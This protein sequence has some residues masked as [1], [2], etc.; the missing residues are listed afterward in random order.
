MKRA[1]AILSFLVVASSSPSHARAA[2]CPPFDHDHAAWTALLERY[3]RGG[4]VDYRAW[5]REGIA[6]LDAYRA[7][8]AAVSPACFAE[9]TREQQLAFLIDAYN[10]STV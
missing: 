7:S 6:P 10:A 3:V 8:L 9:F 1:L 4:V 2:T 5:A